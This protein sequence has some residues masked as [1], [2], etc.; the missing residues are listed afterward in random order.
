M[1]K[2]EDIRGIADISGFGKNTSYEKACQKMLQTGWEWLN[3][4][5]K[6]MHRA[7]GSTVCFMSSRGTTKSF[8]KEKT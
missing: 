8:F 1:T 3:K 7:G 6:A 2:I 4:H 5:K